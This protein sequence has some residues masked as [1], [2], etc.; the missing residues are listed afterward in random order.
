MFVHQFDRQMRT[1]RCTHGVLV[2]KFLGLG[3]RYPKKS[4]SWNCVIWMFPKISSW[5]S[6]IEPNLG[7]LWLTQPRAAHLGP[8]PAHA[9]LLYKP[10]IEYCLAHARGFS[11]NIFWHVTLRKIPPRAAK[12]NA[13]FVVFMTGWG[14]GWKVEKWVG[15]KLQIHMRYQNYILSS[16]QQDQLEGS[17]SAV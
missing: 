15:W 9:G 11:F 6:Y 17:S 4:F 16:F 7:P 8:Q 5:L 3:L 10:K 12:M 2:Y 13:N 1:H 14:A